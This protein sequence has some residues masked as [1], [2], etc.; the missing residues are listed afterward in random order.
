LPEITGRQPFKLGYLGFCLQEV[1]KNELV[2]GFN[3]SQKYESQ[4]G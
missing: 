4:L 2:G 3:P 1:K